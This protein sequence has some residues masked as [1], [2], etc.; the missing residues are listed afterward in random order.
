MLT[1]IFDNIPGRPKQQKLKDSERRGMAEAFF[2]RLAKEGL[3]N[4]QLFDRIMQDK[5]AG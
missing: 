1:R 5:E 4:Q 2:S 3:S